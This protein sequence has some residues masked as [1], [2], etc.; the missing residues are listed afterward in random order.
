MKNNISKQKTSSTTLL[1]L[2]AS[3]DNVYQNKHKQH[4]KKPSINTYGSKTKQRALLFF[5]QN[6]ELV[7]KFDFIDFKRIQTQ[8]LKKPKTKNECKSIVSLV[9]FNKTRLNLSNDC[10]ITGHCQITNNGKLLTETDSFHLESNQNILDSIFSDE[11]YTYRVKE[12]TQT[13]K[14]KIA[15]ELNEFTNI[16]KIPPSIIESISEKDDFKKTKQNKKEKSIDKKNIK[17]QYKLSNKKYALA[18]LEENKDLVKAFDHI[19]FKRIPK[20]VLKNTKTKTITKEQES[21]TTKLSGLITDKLSTPSS[22]PSIPFEEITNKEVTVSR[23]IQNSEVYLNKVDNEEFV[24]KEFKFNRN[25]PEFIPEIADD[26]EFLEP[27]ENLNGFY[28]NPFNPHNPYNYQI[29][30]TSY[31]VTSFYF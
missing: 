15:E 9:D 10:I 4:N 5:E 30:Y 29:Y 3:L 1:D 17:K 19:D 13:P 21:K 22:N 24:L 25:A 16:Y 2:F 12:I 23:K 20:S 7:K 8:F 18:F 27:E 28:F 31:E 6:K 14:S 26:K 11:N